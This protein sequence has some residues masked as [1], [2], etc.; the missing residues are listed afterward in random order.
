[1]DQGDQAADRPEMI[2]TLVVD[3]AANGI[4]KAVV[5]DEAG[6]SQTGQTCVSVSTA[7]PVE[8]DAILRAI[9]EL[10]KGQGAF[11]RVSVGFP[12]VVHHGITQTATNLSSNWVGF[13]LADTLAQ[14]LSKPVRVANGAD[15]LGF[16]AISR[17]GV[18]L[19]ITLETGFG[20]A[21]FVDGKLVSNLEIAHHRF[22][23]KQTYEEQLGQ[24]ALDEAG[25]KK[26]NNRLAKAIHSLETL[27]NYDRLYISGGNAKVITLDLPANVRIVPNVTGLLGGIA[28]WQ[29]N[30]PEPTSKSSRVLK[31][32]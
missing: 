18:E 5:L 1:M 3:T 14:H 13:A 12:G 17:H 20:S 26:W 21:L 28:L 7:E 15:I 22:R 23:K 29:D 10:A 11:D 25:E 30:T 19:V 24:V 2:Q 27:F 31:E 8:P 32:A 6:N 9:A 16:G 4:I